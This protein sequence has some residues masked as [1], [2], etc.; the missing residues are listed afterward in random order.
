MTTLCGPKSMTLI[1]EILFLLT[2]KQILLK[3]FL[4]L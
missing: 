1:G 4:K 2:I 3:C